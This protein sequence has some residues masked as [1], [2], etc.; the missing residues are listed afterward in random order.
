M[1]NTAI[2]NSV[3]NKIKHCNA[4]SPFNPAELSSVIRSLKGGKAC[5]RD[6]LQAEHFI[7]GSDKLCVYLCMLF[8]AMIVHG[9]VCKGL[10][11]T[12]LVPIVKDKKGDISSK[13]NYRPI[14]ITSVISKILESC[15]LKRYSHLLNTSYNQFGFKDNLSTD[16]CIFSLKHVIDYYSN[17]SSPVYLCYL[18]ASKAFDRLNYWIL[19]DKLLE[20]KIPK[21]IVRILVYWYSNQEFLVRWGSHFSDSFGASNGVRQGGVLSPYLFNVYMDGLSLLLNSSNVGCHIDNVSFNHLMYA[22]DTV[23]IAP[24]ARG[25]QKLILL[26]EDYANNCDIIFNVKKSKYMCFNTGKA[27]GVPKVFLNG[28]PIE[29]V[30]KYKYLGLS[31]C[32]NRKDDEAVSS[33]IRSLYCRGNLIIKHFKFCSDNAKILLFKA[34]CSSFYCSHLWGNCSYESSRKLKVA[35]NRILE[36]L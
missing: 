15:I 29:L 1:K 20:R 31:I 4:D 27:F 2:E 35:Y 7:Y 23:L 33:Q 14:A 19:F 25:L 21:I 17:M 12:I 30:S 8:N 34:F 3:R 10:M 5:G 24:S 26:C 36:F 22:D 18:D 13:D 16:M 32:D 11:D 28:K 6:G 9:F